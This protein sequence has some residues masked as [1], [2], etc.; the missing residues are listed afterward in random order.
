MKLD[1]STPG[2]SDLQ[3]IKRRFFALRNGVVADVYRRAGSPY[4]IVFGLSVV[5]I[6][7]VAKATGLNEN[8]ARLLHE[9]SSTRESRLI[10]PLLMPAEKFTPEEAYQWLS[11]VM[12]AEEAD[13]LCNSLLRNV[14]GMQKAAESLFQADDSTDLQR[15]AAVRMMAVLVYSFPKEALRIAEK[16]LSR[17]CKLTYSAASLV[18]DEARFVLQ[19][20]S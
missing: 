14:E 18:A 7:E 10:A 3:N 15:Y 17:K 6:R 12:S 20:N 1:E 2:F 16:E 19:E 9:N 4:K 5:E 13:I 8:L 11:T